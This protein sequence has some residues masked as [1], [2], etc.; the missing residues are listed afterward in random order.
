MP[1]VELTETF[2]HE[3]SMNSKYRNRD[4]NGEGSACQYMSSSRKKRKG[5]SWIK[6]LDTRARRLGD[7]HDS[8]KVAGR[9]LGGLG[10]RPPRCTTKCGNCT[11]CKP[12]H[13]SVPPG[14]PVTVEYYP[15]AWRCKCGNKLFM[16]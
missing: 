6:A 14:T 2:D 15:E 11:P 8:R 10:S 7:Y 5:C 13:V 3:Q 16:P 9:N 1:K 4:I 12:V